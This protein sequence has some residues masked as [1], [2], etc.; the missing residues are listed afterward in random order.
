[1]ANRDRR[2]KDKAHSRGSKA[3]LTLTRTAI[4]SVRR[5]HPWV[6]REGIVRPPTD[7]PSGAVV[8]LFDEAG[9]RLG[10][11]LWDA[12]SPIAARV[13]NAEGRLDERALIDRIER[14]FAR[15]D[16]LVGPDTDAYRLCNGE[17]DRVPGLVLDRYAHVAVLRLD[18]EHLESWIDRLTGPLARS[19]SARGVRTLVLRLGRDEAGDRRIRTLSGP[20]APDRVMVRENGMVMEVDLAHGQKTGAFLDQRDNRARVRALGK[21]R[22]R[23]LNLYSYTGGFSLAAALGGATQVTSVDV[24]SAAHA[25]A[26]RSFRENGLDPAAH[27]FVSADAF[28]YLEGAARRGDRFDLIISD[29]P[30]FA[31][32]ERAKPRALAAYRKLHGALAQVIAKG[33]VLCAASCS[34]HITAEDFLSTLDDAALGRDDLSLVAMHGQPPDHPTSPAWFEGRYLKFA[35]MA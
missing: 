34:S 32:N 20:D 6:Y 29:P 14:A 17:G 19:L 13:F 8:E 35:V 27:A 30:S 2:P 12:Q 11:G 22:S 16:G 25:T 28:A 5:G 24:A 3:G 33:G 31:P 18:G 21:G 23:V 9:E 1:M 7:L 4:V 10:V 15:R 26:Q